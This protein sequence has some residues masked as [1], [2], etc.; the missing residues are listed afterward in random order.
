MYAPRSHRIIPVTRCAIQHPVHEPVIKVVGDFM[1]RHKINAYDETNHTGTVRHIVIRTSSAT[2]EVMVVLVINADSLPKEAKLA[3]AAASVGATSVVINPHKAKSNTIMGNSFRVLTGEGTIRER[4]GQVWY[5]LSAPSFFQVNPVQ[6]A[7][8][9]DIALGFAN[10]TGNEVVL[11]AHVGVGGMALAAAG[12]AKQV[13]GVDI[14]PQAISDAEKNAAINGITNARF[15]VGAAEEVIPKLLTGGESVPDVVFLDP[16]RKGC[17]TA[18]LD[19]LID[20]EVKTVV[21]VSCDPAT[22]ARDIKRLVQ[23]GYMLDA[24][25]PVDMF[26]MTGKVETVVL[27]RRES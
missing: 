14:V 22:L 24:V 12:K 25:Q 4:I 5:Q 23:G 27:L 1:R 10:L 19:A 3:A 26:P 15:I 20:A 11:D 8:L 13:I 2:G 18:L 7:V 16:P 6:T 9:Y 21:Y 17:D